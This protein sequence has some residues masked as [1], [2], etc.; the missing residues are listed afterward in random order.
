MDKQFYVMLQITQ[1]SGQS[2]FRI[3]VFGFFNSRSDQQNIIEIIIAT[4]EVGLLL[5]LQR[6][7]CGQ[8]SYSY[9]LRCVVKENYVFDSY[10][11][12]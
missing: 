11:I 5:R 2:S 9:A 7:R 10:D 4:K 1:K 12:L 3:K 8:S 6:S